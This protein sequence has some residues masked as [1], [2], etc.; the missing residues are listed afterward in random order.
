MQSQ[1]ETGAHHRESSGG[2]E[3]RAGGTR[4]QPTPQQD[5]QRDVRGEVSLL[6][7]TGCPKRGF[8]PYPK[9]RVVGGDPLKILIYSII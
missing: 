1:E 6:L 9:I 4:P 5:F 7:Y 2:E 3:T 8:A